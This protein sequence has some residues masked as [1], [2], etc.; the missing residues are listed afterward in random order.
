MVDTIRDYRSYPI[1]LTPF[2]EPQFSIYGHALS[3]DGHYIACVLYADDRDYDAFIFVKVLDECTVHQSRIP[4]IHRPY[5]FFFP[6]FYQN[7]TFGITIHSAHSVDF[8]QLVDLKTYNSST[9]PPVNDIR[10]PNA[11]VSLSSLYDQFN[12]VADYILVDLYND[13][14][15]ESMEDPI[16]LNDR[17]K[18][19]EKIVQ[20]YPETCEAKVALAD[21]KGKYKSF[22]ASGDQSAI[23]FTYSDILALYHPGNHKFT[24]IDVSSEYLGKDYT[25]HI[26]P[27]GEY[28][29]SAEKT[30]F[31]PGRIN[32]RGRSDPR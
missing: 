16:F 9:L 11:D 15:S 5:Y 30:F 26:S 1:D 20:A 27:N 31:N 23:L 18:I 28:I 24:I 4:R 8:T 19:F 6:F 2:I 25:V 32:D 21:Q 13:A 3:N 10:L 14:F 17:Q 22:V 12:K 7:N 29:G